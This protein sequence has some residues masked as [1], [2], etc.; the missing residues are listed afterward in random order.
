MYQEFM[1]MSRE[2]ILY[3]KGWNKVTSE[4]PIKKN[5]S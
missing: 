3:G 5:K 1:N 2:D 4:D